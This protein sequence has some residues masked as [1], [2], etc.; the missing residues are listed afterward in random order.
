[1]ITIRSRT[2]LFMENVY[3]LLSII[4]IINLSNRRLMGGRL[5]SLKGGDAS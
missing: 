4:G 3:N 5:I 1:M 2:Y